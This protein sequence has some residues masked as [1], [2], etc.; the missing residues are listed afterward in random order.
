VP[1]FTFNTEPQNNAQKTDFRAKVNYISHINNDFLG[2]D[3]AIASFFGL[4]EIIIGNI[5]NFVAN[6]L[7]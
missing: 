4:K 2:K 5:I 6:V 7:L 1:F 3:C